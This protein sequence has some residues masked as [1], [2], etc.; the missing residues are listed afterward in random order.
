LLLGC[1]QPDAHYSKSVKNNTVDGRN[2]SNG[3]CIPPPHFRP[4]L[5]CDAKIEHAQ[6]HRFSL[7]ASSLSLSLTSPRP[8]APCATAPAHLLLGPVDEAPTP[9][10]A[11]RSRI[12]AGGCGHRRSCGRLP[13]RGAAHRAEVSATRAAAVAGHWTSATP[14]S[15]CGGGR[16]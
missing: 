13:R 2:V 11:R 8:P 1:L 16:R 6:R 10:C 4:R 5:P 14:F 12:P 7:H 15:P 3:G 9:R